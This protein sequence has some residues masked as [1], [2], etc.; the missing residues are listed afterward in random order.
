MR[1]SIPTIRTAGANCTPTI[2][3]Q[4][5]CLRPSPATKLLKQTHAKLLRSGKI[6]DA[7]VAGKL[8]SGIANSH[9]SNLPY[10][11]TFISHPCT[12]LN[13]FSWNSIIRGFA[14][15]SSPEKS[16]S[17]YGQML[18][19]GF[20]PNNYTYPFLL[21]AST[22]L[23]DCRIGL[24]LHATIIRRGLDGL[25]PYIQTSLISFH[26][27]LVSVETAHQLFDESSHR[28]I[29]SWNSLIKGYVASGRHIKAIQMFHEMQD[30][31]N[32]RGDEIT[33]L[34]VV[35]ACAHLGALEMGRWIHSYIDRNNL[36]LTPNLRTALINMYAKCGEIESAKTLFREMEEKDV[37]TWSVMIGGLALHGHAKEAFDLV[38][39][40]QR[41]EVL[42]DSVTITA[43]LCACNHGG[44]VEQG[45]RIFSKMKEDYNIEP[46]IE[47]YGCIVALLG[48]AGRLEEAMDLII[49]SSVKPDVVLWGSLLAA[50]MVHK[51]TKMGEI[52]V[53]EILKLDPENA[54]AHVFLSNLYA[55]FGKWDIVQK[56]RNFMKEQRIRKPPGSSLIE[57]NGVVHEFL[58]GDS[59]HPQ[60]SR[61]YMM[62]DEIS[63][64][65]SLKGQS[66]P[67]GG[68]SFDINE[69]DKEVCLSQH[70]EKLAV[71]F[72]L[73]ST[74]PGSVIRI[75]KNLRICRD[76]HT[77]MKMIS[78]KFGR[79]IVVRDCNRFHHFSGGVCSC[80]D[81]W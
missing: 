27:V 52:V 33:M 12:P 81:Y 55:E 69:E 30:S 13:T 70:S 37:R 3:S 38:E 5:S 17:V 50:C 14:H 64:L 61:I 1:S 42:P 25:D 40:M 58:S 10:A 78:E 51:N 24:S 35:S 60:F 56:V 72:G 53:K 73:V 15:S 57:I 43:L 22:H 46:T 23:N 65:V 18:A 74:S 75:I 11:L 26:A 9:P 59:S 49:R 28:D 41:F 48:R 19:G 54:G 29:T 62:L 77:V 32:V 7:V 66:F 76:C 71:A 63:K 67:T 8:I 68:V 16:I 34:T 6:H 20:P 44:M 79:V 31:G 21:K 47:H 2:L 39:E 4:K 45:R 80:G 36:I